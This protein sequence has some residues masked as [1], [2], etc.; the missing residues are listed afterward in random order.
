MEM[1][2]IVDKYRILIIF[3]TRPE[4][5]K[6]APLFHELKNDNFF[7]VDISFWCNGSNISF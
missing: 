4:C 2:Q 6:L 7:N 5:I 1:N 3:G